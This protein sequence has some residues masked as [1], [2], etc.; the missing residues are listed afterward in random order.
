MTD[1][2]RRNGKTLIVG[3]GPVGLAMALNLTRH[4][5]P[6]RIV[7]KNAERSSK[8][9]A[10]GVQPRTLEIFETMGVL[11]AAL[12]AGHKIFGVSVYA[13]GKH[14]ARVSFEGLES[15]CPFVLVLPQSETERILIDRLCALGIEM[16][17]EV[18]VTGFSQEPDGVTATLRHADGK[19]ETFRTP[20]LL[21]CDGAHSVVRHTLGLPFEGVPYEEGFVLADVKI[22]WPLPEDELTVFLAEEGIMGVFPLGR[23]RHR[24][25]A[26]MPLGTEQEIPT[27]ERIQALMN[28]RGPAGVKVSDPVWLA[29][30]RIQRRM[31]PR[32]REAVGIR[33]SSR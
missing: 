30:F 18:E 16:E 19:Q 26:S 12:E 6:C 22:E 10:L 25:V 4:G 5:V 21:G 15:P 11:D 33:A 1:D 31:T 24:V 32:F 27:I 3:A 29:A 28:E 2:L 7:D 9:K 8:S 17:R 23:E 13:H 20:W 14:L